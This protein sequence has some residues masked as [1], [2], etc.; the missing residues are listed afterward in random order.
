MS[1]QSLWKQITSIFR[2]PSIIFNDTSDTIIFI[3][4]ISTLFASKIS[5]IRW[6]L[7]RITWFVFYT[8]SYTIFSTICWYWWIAFTS[9]R[10]YSTATCTA[11][12][13][14][15]GIWIDEFWL[16]R[17]NAKPDTKYNFAGKELN[18]ILE[19]HFQNLKYVGSQASTSLCVW[20]YFTL[21]KMYE[22]H[23]VSIK[24]RE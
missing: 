20:Q 12:R 22:N 10:L 19:F 23:F 3:I 16:M 24:A 21:S 5:C 9:C 6:T 11:T 7:L 14:E 2:N 4:K 13:V 1:Q 8:I 15:T 17:W 18:F